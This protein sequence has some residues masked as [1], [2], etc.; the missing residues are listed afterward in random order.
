MLLLLLCFCAFALADSGTV[1]HVGGFETFVAQGNFPI[2]GAAHALML[3][4]SGDCDGA[5]NACT[6]VL[7][8]YARTP[9]LKTSHSRSKFSI[10]LSTN[11]VAD[12]SGTFSGRVFRENNEWRFYLLGSNF[13]ASIYW[14]SKEVHSTTII[15]VNSIGNPQTIVTRAVTVP[16]QVFQGFVAN[17]QIGAPDSEN[18][19][20]P[21]LP[22]A[23]TV[24]QDKL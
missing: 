10:N 22:L 9:D 12:P 2:F 17:G 16:Q 24:S 6:W 5:G 20:T 4:W 15:P 7:D 14:T 1:Y 18:V 8:G 13:S 21:A 11:T 19:F 23:K 3:Q